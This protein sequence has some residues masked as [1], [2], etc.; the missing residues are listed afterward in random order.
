MYLSTYSIPGSGL[1]STGQDEQVMG[2][3]R[4]ACLAGQTVRT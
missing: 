2:P 4:A 3:G 1:G